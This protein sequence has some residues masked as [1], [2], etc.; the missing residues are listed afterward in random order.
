MTKAMRR[1]AFFILLAL[2][3]V[4]SALAQARPSTPEP[5]SIALVGLGLV[6]GATLLHGSRRKKR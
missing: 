5:G 3:A 6:A 1:A 2:G 4:P